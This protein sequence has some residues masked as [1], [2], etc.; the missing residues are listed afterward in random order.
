VSTS[1]FVLDP[2]SFPNTAVLKMNRN[3][4]RLTLSN[5]TG[6]LDAGRSGCG[7]EAKTEKV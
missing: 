1:G 6:N 4:G 3:L 5:A 7:D 2:D